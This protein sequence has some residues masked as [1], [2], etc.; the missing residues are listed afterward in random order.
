MNT[1][2]Q[3]LTVALLIEAGIVG[4]Y[5]A[6]IFKR[7]SRDRRAHI[8]GLAFATTGTA[9][10]VCLLAWGGSLNDRP[11]LMLWF[12]LM[13]ALKAYF[14]R[15]IFDRRVSEIAGRAKEPN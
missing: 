1:L 10:G 15:W 6:V 3:V 14:V 11:G 8:A 5:A 7:Y 2:I 4:A 13:W 9:F 12:V